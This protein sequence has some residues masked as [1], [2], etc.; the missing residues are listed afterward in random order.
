MPRTTIAKTTDQ[1]SRAPRIKQAELFSSFNYLERHR[2]AVA[3]ATR[4]LRLL[5]SVDSNMA[6]LAI[7]IVGTALVQRDGLIRSD[8]F[9][10]TSSSATNAQVEPI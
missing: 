3:M 9:G 8:P 6:Q 2:A 1:N 5:N 4:I 7:D 10:P